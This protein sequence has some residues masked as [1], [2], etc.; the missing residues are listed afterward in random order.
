MFR[1]SGCGLA[2]TVCSA[3]FQSPGSALSPMVA[4][5]ALSRAL[6]LSKTVDAS[7]SPGLRT[8]SWAASPQA[9]SPVF[10]SPVLL[11]CSTLSFHS[12]GQACL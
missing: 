12:V 4:R 5:I 2:A 1:G 7:L 6:E 10:T 8:L 3:L 11:A 9:S